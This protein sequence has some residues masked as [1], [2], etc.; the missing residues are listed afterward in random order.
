MSKVLTSFLVI[1]LL[2]VAAPANV[3]LE[4]EQA[5]EPGPIG[6]GTA[7]TGYSSHDLYM[8]VDTNVAVLQMYIQSA[9]PAA[10]DFYQ[11][12]LGSSGGWTPNTILIEGIPDSGGGWIIMPRPVLEFDTYA[13]MPVSG[14]ISG[15]AVNIVPG[16]RAL[17][18]SDQLLDVMWAVTT[19]S[20]S[21]PGKFHVAR[22]TVKDGLEGTWAVWATET[23]ELPVPTY[24]ISGVGPLF[25]PEP[26]TLLVLLGAALLTIRRRR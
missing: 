8:T 23:H 4:W 5:T 3:V 16:S 10:G 14:G 15:S 21:G 22:V 7:P 20:N 24:E 25:I 1:G 18:F 11:D 26:A 19:G 17:T 6:G 13:T 9:S 12:V 2:A